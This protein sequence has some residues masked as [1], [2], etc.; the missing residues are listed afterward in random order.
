MRAVLCLVVAGHVVGDLVSYPE[1][2]KADPA[3]LLYDARV[4]FRL[5]QLLGKL[6]NDTAKQSEESDGVVGLVT[7]PNSGS[8]WM[9]S[10]VKSATGL[11]VHTTY[12]DEP[13][14]PWAR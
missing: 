8:G 11:P 12:A 2:E 9:L 10:L 13:S 14:S 7:Y 4:H 3:S 5:T 1:K 6:Y